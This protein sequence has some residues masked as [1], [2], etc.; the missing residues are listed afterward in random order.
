M[1]RK[2]EYKKFLQYKKRKEEI[3]G[4]SHE[5]EAWKGIE[6][7]LECKRVSQQKR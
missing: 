2:T 3:S 7:V 1:K 4:D 5:E 6:R